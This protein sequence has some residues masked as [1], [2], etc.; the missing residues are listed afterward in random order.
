MANSE[1]GAK[2]DEAWR[3][4]VR[5]PAACCRA[6]GRRHARAGR[7]VGWAQ[8]G[9]RLP[10]LPSPGADGKKR[11]QGARVIRVQV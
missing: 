9:G 7:I 1:P 4:S 3:E 8:F 11:E 6:A 10:V 5:G 2:G